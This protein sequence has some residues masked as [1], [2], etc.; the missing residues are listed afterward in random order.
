MHLNRVINSA[1]ADDIIAVLLENPSLSARKVTLHYFKQFINKFNRICL[2]FQY[3]EENNRTLMTDPNELKTVCDFVIENYAKIVK[4]AKRGKPGE[5][6]KV[7]KA[8]V[9]ES[10][11]RADPESAKKV[12]NDLLNLKS[13]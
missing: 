12:L 9:K 3:V 7:I 4:K 1:L 6:E 10:Q 13:N 5:F 8:V 2:Y 11:N